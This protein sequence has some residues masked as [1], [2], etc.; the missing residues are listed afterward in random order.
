MGKSKIAPS[1]LK[2]LLYHI[3]IISRKITIQGHPPQLCDSIKL[4][5]NDAKKQRFEIDFPLRGQ[6]TKFFRK[7]FGVQGHSPQ[8]SDS[9]KLFLRD[10]K[11]QRFEIDIP[12]KEYRLTFFVSKFHRPLSNS[13][14]YTWI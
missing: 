2:L 13:L 9:I 7:C 8:L 10:A 4:F 6:T 1:D 3:F 11:K 12:S 14:S 5:L